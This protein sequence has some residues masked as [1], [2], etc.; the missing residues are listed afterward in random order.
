MDD[1]HPREPF[2]LMLSESIQRFH[3]DR[4]SG[5]S[6]FA[7]FSSIFSRVI[8]TT[9][10]PSLEVLWFY[11]AVS[12]R[13][14][15]L[16]V[17]K[18][19][20]LVKELLGFMVSCSRCGNGLKKVAALAPVVYELHR[21]VGDVM[22]WFSEVR[23][24]VSCL[25]EKVVS[26][27]SMC[28]YENEPGL[29]EM[30]EFSPLLMDVVSVWLADKAEGNRDHV[31]DLR[32]FF[33]M[34]S[35]EVRARISSARE[36]D[37]LAGS[38]MCEVFLLSLSLKRCSEAPRQDLQ[39]DLHQQ[40]VQ[41]IAGFR[42]LNFFDTLL[43]MLLEPTLQVTHLVGYAGESL[44]REVLYDVAMTVQYP[45]LVPVN[46]YQ[47]PGRSTEVAL[48]WLFVA[49]KAAQFLRASGDGT[50]AFS[51]VNA[52]VESCI[53]GQLIEWVICKTGASRPVLSTPAALIGWCLAIEQR[54]LKIFNDEVLRAQVQIVA[55][56]SAFGLDSETSDI[57]TAEGNS[58]LDQEMADSSASAPVLNGQRKRKEDRQD[59]AYLQAKFIKVHCHGNHVKEKFLSQW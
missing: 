8:Q 31:R 52:F 35:D 48:R 26:Y 54:G 20:L 40:A 21:L 32:L 16:E 59:N 14:E 3:S 36:I 17:V 19:V 10:D 2:E 45:F 56:N 15:N 6:N 24:D 49:E 1:R 7:V 13:S 55:F 37:F 33:P 9:P 34:V 43:R 23:D 46:S 18:R 38:V 25:I 41:V 11:S 4:R 50:K 42:D 47:L 5:M 58:I 29:S 27:V 53:P 30:P 22:F 12:F 51:Y 39:K 57:K 28:C 44:L